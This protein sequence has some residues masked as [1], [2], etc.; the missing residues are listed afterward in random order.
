MAGPSILVRILG[1]FSKFAGAA[2]DT[3]KS[4]QSAG[5]RIKGAFDGVLN[6]LNRTGVLGPFGA[7]LAAVSDGLAELADHGKTVGAIMMGVGGVVAGVGV[8]LSTLG[9]K[10]KASHQQLQ[11]AIEATGKSYSDYAS[12]IDAAIKHNEKYG[13]SSA[14]TQDALRQLTEAT[15]D[16]GKALQLLGTATDLAAAK[17]EDLTSAAGQLGKVYNGNTK[18]LKEFGITIDKNTGKT[19]DGKTAT[20]ALADVVA[21]QAAAASDTFSGKI[22]GVTTAV[23]D[24]VSAFGAKYGPAITA[25]GAGITA[26]GGIVEG[27]SA[28]INAMRNSELLAT[29]AE[30]AM[31]APVLLIIAALAALGVAAYLI[32]RNWNTIWNGMKAVVAAVWNWIKTNWPLLLAIIFGPIGIAIDLIVKNWGK[33]KQAAADVVN[34]FRTVWQTVTSAIT[35]A[36]TTA[37]NAIKR[38]WDDLLSFVSGLPGRI[39]RI[40]SGMW[41]GITG[42][43]RGAINALI[44]IWN[45]LKFK[46][47][48]IDAGPIHIGGETIG[49]PQIPHLAQGGLITS[50]GL[51]YAHA[52]EAITPAPTR[53]G[54]A[55]LVQQATFSTEI[56]VDAFMRKAAWVVRTAGV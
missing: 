55:V 10:E 4:A 28:A 5:T 37:I 36:V 43:F 35:G 17:H 33:I 2:N 11:T 21:G 49:V 8:T 6:T 48:K 20:Q 23:E 31:S 13:Q 29:V 15:H 50:S 47:P 19:K 18:L 54:P 32:Y 51:V 9:S 7:S 27:A 30:Y 14:N 44:D 45:G 1:D 42:A 38:G 56:D 26:F 34:W 25:A 22:K 16:P 46:L 41:N 40:A 39:A 52:G 12:Q 53:S 24:Q 3:S